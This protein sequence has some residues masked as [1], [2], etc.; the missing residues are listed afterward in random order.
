MQSILNTCDKCGKTA[1]SEHS[2]DWRGIRTAARG[3]V[4]DLDL[5]HDC[6]T[7]LEQLLDT[8]MGW[9]KPTPTKVPALRR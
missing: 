6:G 4:D 9:D 8:F 7:A 1:D 3:K 2:T 5:C